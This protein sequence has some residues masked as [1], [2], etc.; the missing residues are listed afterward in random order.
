MTQ[1]EIQCTQILSTS[2]C[3]EK[4]PLLSGPQ[5]FMHWLDLF[6]SSFCSCILHYEEEPDSGS[7]DI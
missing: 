5:G 7:T 3:L 2:F 6:D 1:M 4:S